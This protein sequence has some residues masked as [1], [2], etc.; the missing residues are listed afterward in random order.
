[1]IDRQSGDLTGGT[2][3]GRLKAVVT[4]AEMSDSEKKLYE[5]IKKIFDQNNVLNPD[6]KL[7]A[8]SKFTLTHFRDSA[9]PKVM[10]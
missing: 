4:N 10:V 9:L 3:E 1:M 6:I 8:T 7:G 5:E 2:P